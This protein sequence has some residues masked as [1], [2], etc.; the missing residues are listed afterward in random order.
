MK[1]RIVSLVLALTFVLASV[2]STNAASST[3]NGLA[4]TPT[5]ITLK[6]I[7]RL[8]EKATAVTGQQA[9]IVN[10]TRYGNSSTTWIVRLAFGNG[11]DES[12]CNCAGDFVL[13]TYPYQWDA[14]ELKAKGLPFS[15]YEEGTAMFGPCWYYFG[16]FDDKTHQS[17]GYVVAERINRWPNWTDLR[18]DNGPLVTTATGAVD[19]IGNRG[20]R[21]TTARGMHYSGAYTEESSEAFI[22]KH[23]N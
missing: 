17:C 7:S 3:T 4:K 10:A 11:N 12:A 6:D 21:G 16:V 14:V 13:T 19:Q 9:R 5:N 1:K 22:E 20:N 15:S 8:A 23:I 2:L 18:F